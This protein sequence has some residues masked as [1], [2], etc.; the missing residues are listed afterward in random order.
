MTCWQ[1]FSSDYQSLGPREHPWEDPCYWQVN[2][3]FWLVNTDMD[4]D[5]WLVIDRHDLALEEILVSSQSGEVLTK[6]RNCVIV[7]DINNGKVTTFVDK[8]S[9]CSIIISDKTEDS[10]VHGGGSG[11]PGQADSW[12]PP[13]ADGGVRQEY[14]ERISE[15]FLA[16][17]QN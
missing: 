12:W 8:S 14:L 2:T 4:N 11:D 15:L 10:W 13:P 3:G 7:W 5:L 6:T 17:I 9:L 16:H 1:H